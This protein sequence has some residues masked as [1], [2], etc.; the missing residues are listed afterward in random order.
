MTA[1]RPAALRTNAPHRTDASR[2]LLLGLV[3]FAFAWRVAR[4]DF[5]SLWRDEIDAIYFAVRNLDETLAMFVQ[6]AQNGPLFFI[7]L[8]PWL[9]LVGSSEFMLRFPSTAAATL[10]VPLLWQVGRQLLPVR[11][12]GVLLTTALLAALLLAFNPYQVWYAQEG[13]MYATVT[14]LALLAT[15]FWLRGIAR[16][17]WWPWLGYWLTVTVAHV[18]PPADG[19]VDPA[20]R[21][22]VRHCLAAKP[23]PLARVRPGPPGADAAL[24]AHGLVAVDAAHLS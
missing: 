22:L 17:G 13:K 5:Q 6:A 11:Q 16:G 20:A 9:S 3:L 18:H 24:P 21:N 1:S 7:A 2:L 14:C 4:L 15:W 19:G 23:A 10:S 8:R 12:T